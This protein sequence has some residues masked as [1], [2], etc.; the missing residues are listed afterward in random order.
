MKSIV[1]SSVV[2]AL[3]VFS[4]CAD[5]KP[6]VDEKANEVEQSKFKPHKVL[7]IQTE[8]I[9]LDNSSISNML[10]VFSMGI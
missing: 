5:R 2:T 9:S 3:L 10:F 6:V 8:T 1:L 4:G 7:P